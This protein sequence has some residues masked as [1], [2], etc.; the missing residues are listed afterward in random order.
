MK[1]PIIKILCLAAV[2]ITVFAGCQKTPEAPGIVN[3][4]GTWVQ[5]N[6]PGNGYIGCLA[7]FGEIYLVGAN[8][9]GMYYSGNSGNAWV[10]DTSAI[11][12]TS[13]PRAFA[14][15]G[16]TVYCLSDRL[17]RSNNKG[18]VWKAVSVV[19]QFAISLA[20][21]HHVICIGT[22]NSQGIFISNDGGISWSPNK[23]GTGVTTYVV[24]MQGQDIFAGTSGS[25]VYYSHDLGS[26][27]TPVNTNLGSNEVNC[28]AVNGNIVYAGTPKGLYSSS[29]KGL[30]WSAMSNGLPSNLKITS[31]T[32]SGSSM[33]IG[34]NS[35]VWYS[36]NSGA[37]W[38]S[39]GS[40]L[41]DRNI[42]SLATSG[43]DLLA[44]TSSG[45]FVSKDQGQSWSLRGI[46]VTNV[47]S[48]CSNNTM[49]FAAASWN[50]SASYM[51]TSHGSEWFIQKPQLPAGNVYSLAFSSGSLV[52]G[53]D[54]G[55]FV[56]TDNGQSWSSR[57]DGL[58]SWSVQTVGVNG[59]YW[60][61]GTLTTG[62]F[63]SENSGLAWSKATT[64]L[65]ETRYVTSMLCQGNMVYAGTHY[66]GLLISSDN[67]K[68]WSKTGSLPVATIVTGIILKGNSLFAGTYN[69]QGLGLRLVNPTA[70]AYPFMTP[71]AADLRG[72]FPEL[73]VQVRNDIE[74]TSWQ[75]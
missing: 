65:D 30:H 62:L 12:N 8:G 48:M 42:S 3:I 52:A 49:V 57:S 34:N 13:T 18:L 24:A 23:P 36:S 70:P 74:H 9:R 46:P 55:V 2:L 16:D 37:S 73:S 50:T 51:T 19:N 69:G 41:P 59:S 25:G 22:S 40:A 20:V 1:N 63:R 56:S 47:V 64:G 31:I 75:K 14:A 17:Y 61:A 54:T 44:G 6:G 67:G 27:W 29:D 43:A 33:L 11:L 32:A 7:A 66:G 72:Q 38:T 21:N 28:L 4:P 35:G 45:L 10:G 26:H 68:T 15:Y 60:F 71:A 58:S 39:A 5:T 53:T